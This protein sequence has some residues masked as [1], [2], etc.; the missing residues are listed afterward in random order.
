MKGNTFERILR[1]HT[2]CLAVSFNVTIRIAG[3]NDGE[4]QEKTLR[5][6]VTLCLQEGQRINK[7]FGILPW[8]MDKPLPTVY[9][10]DQVKKLPY[11][12]LIQYLRGP[13]QG[14]YIKQVITGRNYKWRVNVTFDMEKPEIFHERWSRVVLNTLTIR[15]FPTQTEQCWSIG[16]CM[17]ST[18]KQDI[19]TINKELEKVTGFDG[20]RVSYENIYIQKVSPKLWKEAVNQSKDLQPREKIESSIS[21]LLLD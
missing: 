20:I 2:R 18:E 21:G 11:D 8:K 5:E 4:N 17:G 6:V 1:K 13:M 12:S 3:T 16:F 10:K 14:R 19:R 9:S 15:D 7:K